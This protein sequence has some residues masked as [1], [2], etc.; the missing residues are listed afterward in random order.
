M[1][2]AVDNAVNLQ[3]VSEQCQNPTDLWRYAFAELPGQCA[4]LGPTPSGLT[5]WLAEPGVLAHLAALMFR[6]AENQ[7]EAYLIEQLLSNVPAGRSQGRVRHGS[8]L[9]V[10]GSRPSDSNLASIQERPPVRL[11]Q[12]PSGRSRLSILSILSKT[13]SQSTTDFGQRSSDGPSV[14][15]DMHTESIESDTSSKKRRVSVLL[16]QIS[17]TFTSSFAGNKSEE[18]SKGVSKV[19]S[20]PMQGAGKH[21]ETSAF[22]TE[23]SSIVASGA[24]KA[25]CIVLPMSKM[26]IVWDMVAFVIICT[27]T[28]LI[29]LEMGFNADFGME[30]LW[31][32]T[33]FFAIDIL[34]NFRTAYFDDSGDL[35]TD[36]YLVAWRYGT[37]RWF[38]I[39]FVSTVPW[40][41][42]LVNDSATAAARRARALKLSKLAKMCRLIRVLHAFKQVKAL[43]NYQNFMSTP[44]KRAALTISAVLIFFLYTIHIGA[45]SWGALGL[46]VIDTYDFPPLDEKPLE[47]CVPGGPCEPSVDGTAW[48]ERFRQQGKSITK[49]YIISAYHATAR[50]VQSFDEITPGNDTERLHI[51]WT[52]ILNFFISAFCL[53]IIQQTWFNYD[54][55]GEQTSRTTNQVRQFMISRGVSMELRMKIERNLEWKAAIASTALTGYNVYLKEISPF[56]RGEL[57]FN[58]FGEALQK[59][60]FFSVIPRAPLCELCNVVS[61]IDV[62]TGDVVVP[63][64]ES[65]TQMLLILSGRMLDHSKAP[66]YNPQQRRSLIG[67]PRPTV[68]ASVSSKGSASSGT[69]SSG[70]KSVA[71]S[72]SEWSAGRM[73]VAVSNLLGSLNTDAEPGIIG[74]NEWIGDASIFDVQYTYPSDIRALEPCEMLCITPDIIS[75]ILQKWPACQSLWTEHREQCFGDVA[76]QGWVAD[77]EAAKSNLRDQQTGSVSEKL[78]KK[79]KLREE[80]DLIEAS[81]AVFKLN[82][83]V[84][85]KSSKPK[86]GKQGSQRKSIFGKA[87]PETPEEDT[88]RGRTGKS[89]LG[90]SG[91]LTVS[92]EDRQDSTED[93]TSSID[94][95][96]AQRIRKAQNCPPGG[97]AGESTTPAGGAEM[98]EPQRFAI[99]TPR[100]NA[101]RDISMDGSR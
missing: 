99:D 64:G 84:A 6:L 66:N 78:K 65:A 68:T 29:P 9:K 61:T 40:H 30:W 86:E 97:Q 70:R 31:F 27:E 85:R 76:R 87:L 24:R 46:G 63:E 33:F 55:V 94:P 74:V 44:W 19:L 48:V 56:L 47:E 23:S 2:A 82:K 96:V 35:I 72:L 89:S 93:M 21:F 8:I 69:S 11:S 32:T 20:T 34:L 38:A 37:S 101:P 43:M 50:M 57:K 100:D 45:C 12:M 98:K 26:R 83:S 60:P 7:P 95:S 10:P 22:M 91:S 16:Q 25:R 13:K 71:G 41:L 15:F 52:Q 14:Q 42:V 77:S 73:S 92:T 5:E 53:A 88:E 51:V 54:L 28:V 4:L 17:N 1:C 67:G 18:L 79:T 59:H 3:P 58:I 81:W 62:V 80:E 90:L 75:N 49:L 36:G 39:D